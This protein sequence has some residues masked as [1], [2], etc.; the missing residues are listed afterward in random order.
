MS[1]GGTAPAE[2]QMPEPEM[3]E[4]KQRLLDA[5]RLV[6]G[7]LGYARA[8]VDDVIAEASTSRATFYR[9]FKSKDDLFSA[10]GR[11][12]FFDMKAVVDEFAAI[13]PAG[14]ADAVRPVLEDYRDLHA[15]HSGIMRA[16]FERSLHL[17]EE[18]EAD[19][20]RIVASFVD[21]MRTPIEAADVPSSVD[22]EVQ[23][24]LLFTLI[25]R[26]TFALSSRWSRLDPDDLA[27]TLAT[28]VHR[29]YLGG[30]T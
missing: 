3:P 4:L 17:P 6:F 16:W 11:S 7:R 22:R 20:S 13:D 10:L 28:M 26:S 19:G 29:A 9:Y 25:E 23:A 24:T 27:P 18:L 2:L 21:E 1:V 15:R 5:G 12:C 14:G 8:T 30:T